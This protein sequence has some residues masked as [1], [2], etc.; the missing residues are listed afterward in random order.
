MAQPLHL[1]IYDEVSD[2]IEAYIQNEIIEAGE[3]SEIFVHI[4]SPGGGVYAGWTVG[5]IL[6]LQK[7]KTT[8]LIE[9]FCASIATYIALSCDV[10]EM[11]ET[12]QFMIHNASLMMVGN[13]NDFQEAQRQLDK[14]DQDLIAKYIK[15]T[16]LR[17]EEVAKMMD[18]ETFLNTQ[19]AIKYGFVDRKMKPLKAVAKYDI[20]I[21]E[22]KKEIE[23]KLTFLDKLVNKLSKVMNVSDEMDEDEAKNMA[24]ELADGGMIF[25]DSEDGELEGKPV[26]MADEEGNKLE[27]PAPDGVHALTDGRSITVEGGVVQSVQEAEPEPEEKEDEEMKALKAKL[28]ELT[29]ENTDLKA[30]LEESTA[31]AEESKKAQEEV[32][33]TVTA[34]AREVKNLKEMTVGESFQVDKPL[35]QPQNKSAEPA[36]DAEGNAWIS[37]LRNKYKN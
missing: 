35:T 13:K 9:G 25:V 23:E 32:A 24:L 34:L 3:V 31:S 28:E 27:E 1:Y 19:E 18:D 17:K 2:G 15:K 29:N 10:V 16:G 12:A 37:A 8:A 14:I 5:N 4:S 20:E 33:E 22:N 11:A 21:M 7:V 30:K 6:A 36:G 26:F